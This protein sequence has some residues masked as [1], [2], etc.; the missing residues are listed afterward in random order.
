MEEVRWDMERRRKNVAIWDEKGNCAWSSFDHRP[1][2][3]AR[4]RSITIWSE[5]GLNHINLAHTST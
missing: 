3:G 4:R 5:Q 1:T 2:G